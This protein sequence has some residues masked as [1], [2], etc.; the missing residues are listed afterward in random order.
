MRGPAGSI[1]DHV[2]TQYQEQGKLFEEATRDLELFKEAFYKADREIQ[3]REA[4]FE[5]ERRAF[6]DEISQLKVRLFSYHTFNLRPSV[7]VIRRLLPVTIL[8]TLM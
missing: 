6:I 3:D 1:V 2:T 8:T 5:Q 7:A 4:M